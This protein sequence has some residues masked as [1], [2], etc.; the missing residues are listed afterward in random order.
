MFNLECVVGNVVESHHTAMVDYEEIFQH[1]GT[2]SSRETNCDVAM[3]SRNLWLKL[4]KLWKGVFA[5][6]VLKE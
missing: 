5:Y 3:C 2:A 1:V 6:D 4:I